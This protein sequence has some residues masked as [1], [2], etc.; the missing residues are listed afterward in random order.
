[1][2]GTQSSVNKEDKLKKHMG[3]TAERKIGSKANE[4]V[5]IDPY[6]MLYTFYVRRMRGLMKCDTST[7]S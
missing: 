5:R 4:R 3:S 7:F 1:M 6:S 2:K